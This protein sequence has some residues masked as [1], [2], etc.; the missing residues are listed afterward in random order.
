MILRRY[1]D[2]MHSVEVNF[3]SKALNEIGFRRDRE[4]AIPVETFER[5]WAQTEERGLTAR[6]EGS[7][8][9]EVEQ[10][11]LQD[12]EAQIRGMEG[13]LG[14]GEVLVVLSEQGVDYPKT[15]TDQ[16]TVV[17]QGENRFYFHLEV[18][19]PLRIGR[20]RKTDATP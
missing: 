20:Y 19:P 1:G 4:L 5:S 12:L 2:S 15:H 3:D 17:E 11:L 6:A 16:K 10:R 9:D 13:E 7:V 14:E 8:Q 18:D